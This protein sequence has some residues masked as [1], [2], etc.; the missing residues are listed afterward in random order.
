MLHYTRLKNKHR[1]KSNCTSALLLHHQLVKISY[2]TKL[3]NWRLCTVSIEMW[4]RSW[5][6]STQ[7]SER[8]LA[9]P[10]PWYSPVKTGEKHENPQSVRIRWNHICTER[11]LHAS[12]LGVIGF[13]SRY[14]IISCTDY[15]YCAYEYY[16]CVAFPL[17]RVF[18][19]FRA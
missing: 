2:L 5:M 4:G 7:R 19:D 13:Q 14:S 9:W 18:H 10:T 12:H 17:Y 6:V 8:R 1:S 16:Q 11:C 3:F 15:C